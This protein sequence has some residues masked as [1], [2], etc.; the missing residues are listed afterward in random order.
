MFQSV[1][2]LIHKPHTHP[3][4]DIIG[5]SIQNVVT[6]QEFCIS[7]HTRRKHFTKLEFQGLVKII[8]VFVVDTH[9]QVSLEPPFYIRDASY[10]DQT[11]TGFTDIVLTVAVSV[12]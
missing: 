2:H 8:I 6:Q 5:V 1:N 12:I 3:P 4:T 11:G 7:T 9:L 10:P